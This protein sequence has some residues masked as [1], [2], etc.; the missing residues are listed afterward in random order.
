MTSEAQASE[1]LPGVVGLAF[2][3]FPLHP[4]DQPGTVRARHL[5]RVRVPM[6]FLQGAKDG[7]ARLDLLE[8]LVSE[9]GTRATLHLVAGG[10]H[11]FA[12]KGRPSREVHSELADALAGWLP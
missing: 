1:P 11:S 5:E 3:G 8:P 10:D 4:P 7:F 6:L 12:V 9:L 2:L